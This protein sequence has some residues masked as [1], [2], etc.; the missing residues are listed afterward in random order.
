MI[1]VLAGKSASG[2]DTL[3]NEL[4]T[5]TDARPIV[6]YT[7]RP[8]RD[9]EIDGVDYHF[10]SED[11]FKEIQDQLLESRSYDT[12]FNGIPATWYYGSPIV[13]ASNSSY[14]AVLDPDG[15]K[16]YI[17][18][19]GKDNL[20]IAYIDCPDQVRKE[21]AI[22]RGSFSEAEWDRRAQDDEVRFKS[23]IDLANGIYSSDLYTVSELQDQ[24]LGNVAEY[25]EN[26]HKKSKEIEYERS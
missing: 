15:V 25:K 19:Y 23:I 8:M 18:A 16:S 6:S 1:I 7:T 24:I 11:K 10:V 20:F 5:Y 3:L 21:R 13:D 9:K 17:D 4:I 26:L 12:L 2:K 14:V 22:K